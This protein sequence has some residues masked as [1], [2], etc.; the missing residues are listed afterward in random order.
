MKVFRRIG[1][2]ILVVFLTIGLCYCEARGAVDKERS[3]FHYTTG[4]SY[5]EKGQW[6]KAI[7]EYNEAI[8]LDPKYV[9]AYFNRGNAYDEKGQY[10][11]AISDFTKAIEINP[12]FA[13]AYNNRALSS[14]F[15]REYDKAWEDVHKA[16]N[17][18]YQVHPEFLKTLRGASGRE[19]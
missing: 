14:Y 10:K 12:R 9:E 18:G 4:C 17:L 2:S 16:Q 13:E 19:K 6:D 8:E 3:I 1:V 11:Q 5:L 7:A 15:K